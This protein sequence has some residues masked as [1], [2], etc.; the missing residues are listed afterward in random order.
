MSAS[1][2]RYLHLVRQDC[3]LPP[4]THVVV[5]CRDS[6]GEDQERSVSQQVETAREFCAA[7]GLVLE[8]AYIDEAKLSSN[9]EKRHALN[10]MLSDLSRRFRQIRNLE[11]HRDQMEKHPFGVIVWKSNRLGRDSIET[12]Y[13]KADLRI[14]GITIVNLSSPASKPATPRSMRCSR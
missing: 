13:I 5:H 10:D 9:T 14:R 6:G 2:N 8:R 3:P 4:G 11:K 1:D 12:T 7:H